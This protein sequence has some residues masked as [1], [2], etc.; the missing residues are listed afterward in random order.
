MIYVLYTRIQTKIIPK[1]PLSLFRVPRAWP[2][3]HSLDNEYLTSKSHKCLGGPSDK[4]ISNTLLLGACFFK[5]PD[6]VIISGD[7]E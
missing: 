7:Q 2:E 4:N 5:H 6:T 3:K 1:G